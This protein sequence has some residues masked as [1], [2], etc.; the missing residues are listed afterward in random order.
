MN[1]DW[2][3]RN[4]LLEKLDFLLKRRFAGSIP[5][6]VNMPIHEF[7]SMIESCPS[8][9]DEAPDLS[10]YG[11]WELTDSDNFQICRQLTE[12]MFELYRISVDSPS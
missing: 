4:T 5:A 11:K 7:Y 1:K 12:D 9:Y 6:Q 3:S 10:R 8:V 2:I